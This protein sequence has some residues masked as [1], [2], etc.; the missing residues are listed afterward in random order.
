MPSMN[1]HETPSLLPRYEVSEKLSETLFLFIYSKHTFF[2]SQADLNPAGSVPDITMSIAASRNCLWNSLEE[3]IADNH[4][5]RILTQ[6]NKVTH[7]SAYKN[8][9][10]HL[11][12]RLS[13]TTLPF[14]IN[15]SIIYLQQKKTKFQSRL[16]NQ[17]VGDRS[18]NT[19]CAQS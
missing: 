10:I 3:K 4:H 11:H 9:H 7:I 2:K 12:Q 19:G 6:S 16:S 17:M 15:K 1:F 18:R 5:R 13:T 14:G 8:E